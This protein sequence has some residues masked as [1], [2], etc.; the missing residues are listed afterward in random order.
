MIFDLFATIAKQVSLSTLDIRRNRSQKSCI[1]ALSG[2][3]LAAGMLAGCGGGGGQ[4][5][6]NA[7]PTVLSST[8]T[9][10][11]TTPTVA[12]FVPNYVANLA[13]VRHWE[14]T[15]VTISVSSPATRDMTP[16]VQQAIDLWKGKVGQDV[17]FQIV[18]VSTDSTADVNIR[19]VDPTTLPTDSIGRTDVVFRSADQVLTSA[20]V[21]VSQTLPDNFQVQVITHELGHALGIQGHSADNADLMYT[22]SHLP[23][24]I[25]PSDQNTVLWGYSTTRSVSTAA[26]T[27]LST[28][29]SICGSGE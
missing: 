28:A 11:D 12:S 23:T 14:K 18:P 10:T 21:Q 2:V 16:L 25:T 15:V 17:V 6:P 27:G 9:G 24:A 26:G 4:G 29:A 5:S 8:T 19:W 3:F 20:Q 13:T 7:T 1:V 22:N